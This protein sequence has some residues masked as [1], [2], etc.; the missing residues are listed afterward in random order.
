MEPI[1]KMVDHLKTK[2]LKAGSKRT[3]QSCQ[4]II[5]NVFLTHQSQFQ[6]TIANKTKEKSTCPLFLGHTLGSIY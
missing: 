2:S 5:K 1:I 4:I 6:L 3:A